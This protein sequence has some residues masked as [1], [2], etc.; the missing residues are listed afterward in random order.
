MGYEDLLKT[1]VKDFMANTGKAGF[2]F[3]I[4]YYV[5]RK[6]KQFDQNLTKYI[7]LASEVKYMKRIGKTFGKKSCSIKKVLNSSPPK[8]PVTK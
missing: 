5:Q 2:S 4:I 1:K 6:R 7:G 3:L 8:I